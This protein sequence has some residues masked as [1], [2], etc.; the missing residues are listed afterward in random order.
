M[1]RNQEGDGDSIIIGYE[2]EGRDKRHSN[3]QQKLKTQGQGGYCMT[4]GEAGCN[5]TNGEGGRGG[6]TAGTARGGD[7]AGVAVEAGRT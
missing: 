3:L 1:G 5:A 6:K 2:G 7:T 4:T